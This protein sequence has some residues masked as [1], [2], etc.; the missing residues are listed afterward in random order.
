MSRDKTVF[1]EIKVFFIIFVGLFVGEIQKQGGT[2]FGKNG[3]ILLLNSVT[4]ASLS[5]SINR[6]FNVFA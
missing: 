4:S 2:N 3:H 1:H 6:T 5:S